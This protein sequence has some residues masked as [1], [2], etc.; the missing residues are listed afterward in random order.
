MG[1]VLYGRNRD[2]VNDP[3]ELGIGSPL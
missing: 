2:V 1:G 3:G